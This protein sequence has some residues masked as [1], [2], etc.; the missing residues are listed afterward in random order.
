MTKPT[1]QLDLA[2]IIIGPYRPV[3]PSVGFTLKN[4]RDARWDMADRAEKANAL[5]AAAAL[6]RELELDIAV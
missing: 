2:K 4:L 3:D 6:I 5:Q 1:T